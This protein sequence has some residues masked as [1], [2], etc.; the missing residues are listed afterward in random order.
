MTED[1]DFKD[2]VR[3]RAA[4]TGESYQAAR[5]QLQGRSGGVSADVYALW[6][7]PR[8]LVLGCVVHAG[9]LA[10]GMEVTVLA[11]LEGD[12]VVHRGTVASLRVGKEERRSVTSGECGI[13]LDPPFLGYAERGIDMPGALKPVDVVPLPYRVVSE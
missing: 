5:R 1:R 6:A 7:H 9:A 11:G 8:G 10:E 2:V 12:T 4:K 3:K 13:T